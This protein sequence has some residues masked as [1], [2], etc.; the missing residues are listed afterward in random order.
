MVA[1]VDI[2]NPD[3][4]KRVLIV[5]SNPAVSRQ[6]GWP[7]GF[8]WS[9]LTHPYWEFTEHGYQ[10]DIASPEGGALEAD[11][12]S[13]PLD[14]TGYSAHDLISLGFK[15]SPT[16]AA[17]VRNSL[18]LAEVDT[19]SYDA[20]FL[21]GGQAP[22]YTFYEDTRI[23][24]LVSARVTANTLTAVVCHATC[25]L[26]K[27][28]LP[29]GRLVVDGRTWTGFANSEE[30]FADE[31]VGQQIQPF[32]IED[33]ARKLDGTNFIVQ[34]RFKPHAVRDGNLITG[35]QQYS[36]AAAAKLVIEAL[37]A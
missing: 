12:W 35:Q 22:M 31:F 26:L 15:T 37:G 11:S 2:L 28:T 33:D 29:D 14:D 23:H 9:E 5:A 27:A 17:L 25:V 34:S 10:V 1:T 3:K 20:V 36:G 16:H 18:K 24:D 30:D 32:R 7:I 6:T 8:W 13:D 21:V 4:P 19:D